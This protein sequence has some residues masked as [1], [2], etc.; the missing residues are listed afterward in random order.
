MTGNFKANLSH[1]P[2]FFFVALFRS[3]SRQYARNND[4]FK[5]CFT[6]SLNQQLSSEMQ[7]LKVLQPKLLSFPISNGRKLANWPLVKQHFS[8]GSWYWVKKTV[9]CIIGVFKMK[10]DEGQDDVSNRITSAFDSGRHDWESDTSCWL[11]SP[12]NPSIYPPS[13]SPGVGFIPMLSYTLLL[14]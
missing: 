11:F 14:L 6:R 3:F 5:S 2:N 8:C 9:S 4:L 7:N 12:I 13:A 1:S 10:S